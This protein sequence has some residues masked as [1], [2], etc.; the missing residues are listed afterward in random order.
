MT[1]QNP[2]PL[3]TTGTVSTVTV[4]RCRDQFDLDPAPVLAFAETHTCAQSEEMIC[5]ALEDIATRLDRLQAARVAGGFDQMCSPARRIGVIA[6]GLGLVDV[7]HAAHHVRIAAET[8]NVV[9][10][11]ATLA[12]LERCFD[13]GISGIWAVHRPNE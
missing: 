2:K 8:G 1:Y 6:G 9:A 4:L 11:A 13:A 5:R 12:R 10:V 7:G 3:P